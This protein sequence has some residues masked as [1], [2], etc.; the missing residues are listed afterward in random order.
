MQQWIGTIVEGA[1]QAAQIGAQILATSYA[2]TKNPIA[3]MAVPILR[4]IGAG[5]P[6]SPEPAPQKGDDPD[7]YAFDTASSAIPLLQQFLEL[8]GDGSSHQ[9]YWG[10]DWLTISGQRD[11]RYSLCAFTSTIKRYRDHPKL[12]KSKTEASITMTKILYHVTDVCTSPSFCSMRQ[13]ERLI[14]F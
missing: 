4:K 1:G 6:D 5:S 7:D 8:M 10:M 12:E 13:A 11:A 2:V 14:F 9:G 3:A